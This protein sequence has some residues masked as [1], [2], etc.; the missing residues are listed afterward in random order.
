MFRTL[1]VTLGLIAMSGLANAED[2]GEKIFVFIGGKGI[3]RCELDLKTG[4]LSE[5]IPVGD[6]KGA[7]FLAIHP[8][9]KF[10]YSVGETGTFNGKQQGAVTA[11]ALDPKSG[12][13][14]RLNQQSAGGGGPCHI[15]VNK[16]GTHAFVANYGGGSCAVLPI[17]ADGKLVEASAFHQHKGSSANKSRQSGPHA[18]SIN[19]DASN[20]FAFV[21]DLGLD[22]VLVYKFDQSKGSL[23]PND[24]PFAKLAPGAGPRHFAFHTSGKYA[25]VINELDSTVTAMTY[26]AAK[27][28]LTPIQTLTTLPEPTKGNSTAEVVVHPSGKFLYGSNRGHNSIAI[29][30]I[31]EATGKLTAAGHQGNDI[32]VPRNFNIDPTGKFMLVAS[33]ESNSVIVFAIDQKTGALT[34]TD[35]KIAVPAPI[36]VKFLRKTS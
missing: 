21:A 23:E 10:L 1:M 33:Q 13:V 9:G 8:T 14:K 19:L 6:A 29:F 27:G 35:V 25:Y 4:K 20:K 5:P 7:G 12:D 31:D 16:A 26:D 3:S 18:H 15:T 34:P 11:W 30:Q 36:C 28:E 32:K 24:P 17:D 22:Q 2:S